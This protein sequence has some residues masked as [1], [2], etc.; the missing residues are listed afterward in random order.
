MLFGR[1]RTRV[2]VLVGTRPECL[3]L[4]SLVR[5]L[6]TQPEIECLLVN[7][8]QQRAMA[9]R[10]L[11]QCGLRADHNLPAPLGGSL[12][13]TVRGLCA[14]IGAAISTCAP[15][16]VVVQGDTSTAYAG[17]LAAHAAGVSLA[18]VEAGLR[19]AHPCRPFPE[20]LF[21]RRIA[22]L[23]A[24]HFPPT[25]LAAV[26][27]INEGITSAKIHVC[28][29]TI[30]DLLRE[31][32]EV[33]SDFEPQGKNRGARPKETATPCPL[34][35]PHPQDTH[36]KLREVNSNKETFSDPTLPEN[37]ARLLTLTLHRRENYGNG[38]DA[39]G[40]AVLDLLE[41]DPGL[42]VIC[43][44]HPN[45]IVGNRIRRL[46]GAHPRIRLTEPMDYA[47][48][49]RLLARSALVVTDSGGIQEEAPYLGVSVIVVRENTERPESVSCGTTRLVPA[50]RLAV[51]DAACA[52]LRTSRQQPL[53]FDAQ[54]PFG[55]GRAGERIAT[56]LLAALTESAPASLGASIQPPHRSKCYGAD[57]A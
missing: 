51:F 11:A 56:L 45:P 2:L 27:L 33:N 34:W 17:A 19:T 41:A 21:R 20:E 36:A 31:Q 43:P 47:P 5:I 38:L 49:V 53:P 50:Q 32:C 44:V 25:P 26:N 13:A 10:S 46:L 6:R 7:S 22:P 12:S 15:D 48:F 14:H 28:G 42:G 16:A 39:V 37:C 55:D 1:R 57:T 29:N 40:A 52:A 9:E 18:H 8:G 23:A 24:L 35:K 4:T 30:I 3:K 54:A